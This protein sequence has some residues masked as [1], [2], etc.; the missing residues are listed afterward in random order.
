MVISACHYRYFVT[1]G[2][3]GKIC[4][5][6]KEEERRRRQGLL[7]LWRFLGQFAGEP[8]T[9]AAGGPSQRANRREAHWFPED[10]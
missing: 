2:S 3:G 9:A 7:T 4:D 6:A 5:E 1:G 8:S 10:V